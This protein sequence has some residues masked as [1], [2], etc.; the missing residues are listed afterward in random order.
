MGVLEEG[1][2]RPQRRRDDAEAA[3]AIGALQ[4]IGAEK[5]A[6]GTRGQI[7]WASAPPAVVEILGTPAGVAVHLVE[8]MPKIAIG[9]MQ[10]RR[11]EPARVGRRLEPLVHPAVDVASL[12]GEHPG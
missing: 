2:V 8:L 10:Q 4:Q 3:V 9:M 12:A 1:G 11:L 5:S 7:P 6:E